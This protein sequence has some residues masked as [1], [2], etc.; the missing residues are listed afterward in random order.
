[1][2][3]FIPTLILVV[4]CIGGFWYASSK[5]FF[6]E[7]KPDAPA[8]VT[9]K[10]EDVASYAIKSGDTAVEIQQKDGKWTMAKPSP[11]PLNDFSTTGWVDSFNGA[12]KDKTVD[13][14]P[15]D[16]AQFGLDK[17]KQEFS[18]TM[19][20]GTTHTLSI[21][22]PV[23]VQGFDYAKFS[24]SPEVFQ[25]SDTTVKA[26]DKKPLD[27]MEKSPVTLNYEQVRSLSVDWKGQQWT[28]TKSEP[29]KKSFEANWKLG[30]KEVKG[31]DASNYLDK[32]A[33]LSTNEL[34]KPASDVKGLD[35][36]EL[37][38]MVKEADQAGK[39]TTNVYA[40]KVEGSNVWI[41][42]QGGPWAFAVPADS[43]QALSDQGK[44]K[45]P[46]TA[47]PTDGTQA[48]AGTPSPGAAPAGGK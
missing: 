25:I 34:V 8:L 47:A 7:K 24:G 28:L 36:P 38:I 22:D 11:L 4:L 6:K 16:L 19:K 17:P 3:K 44:D 12:T 40:G 14:N 39:E 46:A 42:Q 41:A 32:A 43:V 13:A 1:M 20:D 18:V 45:P 31:A 35:A 15:K 2:K 23:A 5:D 10:K 30:D 9:V 37:K 29:D 33:F 27:F 48:P 26:L 21:G